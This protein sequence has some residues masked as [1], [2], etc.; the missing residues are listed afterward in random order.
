MESTFQVL[1]W[2]RFKNWNSLESKGVHSHPEKELWRGWISVAP[3]KRA[4]VCLRMGRERCGN[5]VHLSHCTVKQWM[6]DSPDTSDVS[7]Q[8]I[9]LFLLYGERER[10]E[11]GRKGGNEKWRKLLWA[12]TIEPR[13]H[14]DVTAIKMEGLLDIAKKSWLLESMENAVF[15]NHRGRHTL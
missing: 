9:Q 6:C 15:S 10:E 7:P 13:Q 5:W 1:P 2:A 12:I 8:D 11:R 14:L 4:E 3:S